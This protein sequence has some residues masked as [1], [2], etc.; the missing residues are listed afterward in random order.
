M[1]YTSLHRLQAHNGR[2]VVVK[3]KQFLI[4]C[5]K[6]YVHTIFQVLHGQEVLGSRLKVMEAD[7]HDK[8]DSGRK[9]LRID[10]QS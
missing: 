10:D 3:S 1:H 5:I 6:I 9:R 4:G 8:A 7:P 2:D